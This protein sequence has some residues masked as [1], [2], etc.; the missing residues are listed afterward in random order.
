MKKNKS[1]KIVNTEKLF[2][3]VIMLVVA[4]NSKSQ[5]SFIWGKQFGT[6]NEEYVRNFVIDQ[7]GYVYVSG[8]TKGIMNDKDF[9]KTDG[10]IIKV[11]S[12]GNTIWS[13][14]FG[15]KED[16]DIQFSA[17][18]SEGSVYITG[19]TR[20]NLGFSNVGKEDVFIVKY[21]N[22][23]KKIWTKQFGTDSTDIAMGIFIDKKGYLYITGETLGKLGENSFGGQDAFIMQLDNNGKQLYIKQFGT[24]ER[25]ACS[26]I[27]GDNKGNIYVAGSTFGNIGSKNKGLMDGFIGHFT[28]EGKIVNYGQLGSEGF[29]FFTCILVDQEN[30]V[31][32][33]GTTAGNFAGQHLGEG[34]CFILKMNSQGK[35]FWN[36]Q[37]GTNKHDGVKAIAFDPKANN[38]ILVSG[39]LSLPPA[40]AFV[41]MYDVDGLLLWE[42]NITEIADT[43]DSSGKYVTIDNDGFIYH[44][45]LTMSS[46]YSPLIGL[47]DAY[48]V[49]FKLT[50]DFLSH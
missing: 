14:Q 11:D 29:D 42:K 15:S 12:L 18:D 37:F 48:L 31:Y 43:K 4:L 38:N 22:E 47:T 33:G 21:S 30:N 9:G 32:V 23:G 34:D 24:S 19:S 45:G 35:L 40:H 49:K 39:L 17:I 26:S 36:K 46:L 44:I 10:F 25:D 7:S 27:T 16:E 28:D 5:T 50:N 20:G 3:I 41:R 6:S 2:F 13:R 8:N 1:T